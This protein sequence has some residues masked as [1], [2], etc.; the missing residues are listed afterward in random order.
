[1]RAPIYQVDA[2][3]SELFRGNP[4]AVVILERWLPDDTL[5]SIAAENNLSETAFVIPGAPTSGLRWFTP[6]VEVDLCGHATLA[7][8]HVLLTTYAPHLDKVNFSTRS[9][10][11]SVARTGDLFTLDFPAR[12]GHPVEVS[13]A[14]T[15]ALG[16][17]PRAAFRARDLMAVFDTEAQVRALRPRFELVAALDAFAVIVSAPGDQVDFVSRFFAPR[18]GVPE[19]PVTGS[20]HCTLVPYWA[21]RLGRARLSAKQLSA[22]SGDLQCELHGD[23]VAI[24]GRTVEYLRGEITIPDHAADRQRVDRHL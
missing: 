1:M 21:A 20:A 24:G 3:A 8:G 9:G 7:A 23:R 15:S 16:D 22:R 14:L 11:L 5:Q 13:E 12:A 2:F 19:D 17:R 4:A 10:A 6:T 18:A